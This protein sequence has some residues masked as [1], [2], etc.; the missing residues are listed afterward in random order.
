MEQYGDRFDINT[1]R[2]PEEPGDVIQV[3]LIRLIP[4]GGDDTRQVLVNPH[5]ADFLGD[6]DYNKSL[7]FYL[8][9]LHERGFQAHCGREFVGSFGIALLVS[10]VTGF[11]IYGNFMR[12]MSFAQIRRGQGIR[13]VFDDWHKL[14]GVTA[15]LFNLVIAIAGI[16]LG[17]SVEALNLAG[18]QPDGGVPLVLSKAE[19]TIPPAEDAPMRVDY[20][21]VLAAACGAFPNFEP[22]S[23]FPTRDG[24]RHVLFLGKPAGASYQDG[25]DKVLVDKANNSVTHV[26]RVQN[27]GVVSKLYYIAEPLHFGGFGG[28]VLKLVYC[29]FGLAAGVLSITGFVVYW[30]RTER[31]E[32]GE[33]RP[34]RAISRLMRWCSAIAALLVLTAVSQSRSACYP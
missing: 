12:S 32:S 21:A 8:R 31:K 1:V 4:G 27:A 22:Q 2:L 11:L 24:R 9:H 14:G 28:I 5:T 29:L 16:W 33:R 6:R 30:K 7:T 13:A 25:A 10:T 15:L 34:S 23:L 17:W 3:D 26:F 18:K 20:D 19:R